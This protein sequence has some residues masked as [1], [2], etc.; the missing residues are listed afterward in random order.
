MSEY[1]L[2]KRP[3]NRVRRETS[4][5]TSTSTSLVSPA[6]P[7]T[8]VTNNAPIPVTSEGQP[9]ILLG[10]DYGTT[11]TGLAW[12]QTK[13]D[14]RVSVKDIK[15]FQAWPKKNSRKV[16]SAYSYSPSLSGRRCKQWGHDIDDQS[17][18][19]RW[20][21]LELEPR[22]GLAELKQLRELTKGLGLVDKLVASDDMIIKNDVPRHVSKAPE[23]VL[24]DYL[25]QVIREWYMHMKSLGR[26]TLD[27]VPLDVVV[28]HPASWS[29]EA[30]NKTFR[31]VRG[32]LPRR[33]FPT[34]RDIS[35]T[36][37]PEAC[38][39]YTVQDLLV[40]DHFPLI[41]G[42]C[43]VLCDAGGGTVDLASYRVDS[44][45]PLRLVQIGGITGDKFGATNVDRAF[46]EWLE[47]KL[48]NLDILPKDFGTGGHFIFKPIG[49]TLLEKFERVK[50][51]FTGDE[52]GD[53]ALPRH[54]RV[55]EDQGT[56]GLGDT[57][58][59]SL[60]KSDLRSMFDRSVKGT[61]G[62]VARQVVQVESAQTQDD[63]PYTV[64][65]IFVAGG[66][67]ESEYLLNKIR[68]Y[69]DTRH[70]DVQR[71]D[72]CWAGVV[73][74][75]VLR[76]MGI[77]IK[78][79]PPVRPCPRHYGISVRGPHDK[80]SRTDRP[81]SVIWKVSKGDMLHPQLLR[82]SSLKTSCSFSDNQ[83]QSN[84]TIRITFV[85]TSSDRPPSRYSDISHSS[86]EVK[87]LD[88]KLQDIPRGDRRQQGRYDYTVELDVDIF[89]TDVVNVLISCST[90][91]LAT[92][93]CAP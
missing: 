88:V 27:N 38:A 25:G 39:L 42:E 15:L 17:Q 19:M 18:V 84:S 35:F 63:I 30:M 37:E 54:T 91:T 61:V 14:D 81:Y 44:I 71:A 58:V 86:N 52:T 46:L 60:S 87:S 9:R 22:T 51:D 62:L 5:S 80:L 49:R 8:G 20:T 2:P 26:H 75:A 70:I 92:Y 50:H 3:M 45:E 33:M 12:I 28:T 69:G 10:I 83:V 76:G 11:Y 89:V 29:Y 68:K 4:T 67:A 55:R 48:E 85:A 7:I 32:A 72:D 90:K 82:M 79:S 43:F 64:T 16:P 56:N 23:D 21:K 1:E 57:G 59:I 31:A 6:P 40:Q 78:A 73:K 34:L 66:F 53:I 47:P 65:N 41:P 74:G 36:P 93:S 24:R 13:G 77:G